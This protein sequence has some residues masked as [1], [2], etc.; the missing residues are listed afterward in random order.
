ML[1][2]NCNTRWEQYKATTKTS[3]TPL[4]SLVNKMHLARYN[5]K[6]ACFYF[7]HHTTHPTQYPLYIVDLIM[8]WKKSTHHHCF[9]RIQKSSVRKEVKKNL[10]TSKIVYILHCMLSTLIYYF[11]F[12]AVAKLIDNCNLVNHFCNQSLL[13]FLMMNFQ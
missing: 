5:C 7:I 9:D 12:G 4:H 2:K 3:V 6:A 13:F 8:Q 11:E 10:N 1:Q